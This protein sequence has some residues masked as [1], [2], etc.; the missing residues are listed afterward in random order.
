MVMQIV[1]NRKFYEEFAPKKKVL[2]AAPH[3]Q[4]H[5]V[6][7]MH[8]YSICFKSFQWLELHVEYTFFFSIKNLP[9]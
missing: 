6:L 1:K 3:I 8:T 9:F 7:Y 4:T 5:T 2:I